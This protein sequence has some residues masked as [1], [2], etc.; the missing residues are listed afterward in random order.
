[1]S[2]KYVR[3]RI[4]VK[5]NPFRIFLTPDALAINSARQQHLE[6]LKLPLDG[7]HVLEVGAGIGLHTAF[8]EQRGCRVLA[9]DGRADNVGEMRRRHPERDVAVLDLEQPDEIRRLGHFDVVYCYGTLYHLGTPDATLR[10]LSDV[11]D[12]I[13]LET[14]CTPGD[15]SVLHIVGEQEGVRNQ[16]KSSLGCRPTRGWVLD[17]LKALW[18]HAYVSLSQPDHFE[19]PLDW[20]QL[21]PEPHATL[22][23]RAVFVGSRT[24]LDDNALL[25]AT[26]PQCQARLGGAD[27]A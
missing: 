20:R 16:A 17:T 15:E 5:L 1:M 24:L 12:M 19:F 8:F 3:E 6:S 13:L 22:N 23:T 4:A 21:P 11:C 27:S 10:A 2:I 7:K 25:T 9:T 18:G 14:C 26:L